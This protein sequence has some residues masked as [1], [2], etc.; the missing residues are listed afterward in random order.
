MDERTQVDNAVRDGSSIVDVTSV[1]DPEHSNRNTSNKTTNEELIPQAVRDFIESRYPK[2][3]SSQESGAQ[4]I[5]LEAALKLL[6]SSFSGEKPED[7]EIFLEK[8]EFAL[9]CAQESIKERLL[10]GIQV[11]LTGKARQAVKFK[12]INSWNELK[13][14][15][16]SA[17][18]PQRTTTYLFSELY[19]IKQ[20]SGEDII[21]YANRVEQLQTLILKQETDGKTWEV[22]QALEASIKKQTIQVFVEGLGPLKDFIKARNPPNLD[23]AIQAAREEERVR[24]SNEETKKLY[25]P[26]QQAAYKKPT[27]FNCGKIGHTA[28]D[29]KSGTTKTHPKSIPST[30]SVKNISCL[31]CKKP[32]HM[33]K[34]CR[35]RAYVNSRK[36]SNNQGNQNGPGS[37]GGRPVS[38]IKSTGYDKP[39][40]SKQN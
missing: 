18:E 37:S 31:Y 22:A 23:K 21:S 14:T 16:K 8:C 15:L 19:S 38:E 1:Q 6:P 7:T 29:C 40:T 35:K 28:K 26:S 17:L 39:S 11:R 9:T 36:D 4:Y 13:D 32:G 5:G 10:K 24:T 34:D 30:T 20:K 12:T 25:G 27:C 2:G 3:N 33:L